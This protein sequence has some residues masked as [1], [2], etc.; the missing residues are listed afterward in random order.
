MFTLLFCTATSAALHLYLRRRVSK[1]AFV[2]GQRAGLKEARRIV[3]QKG[4]VT[5]YLS[6]KGHLSTGL[7]RA[8]LADDMA[9]EIGSAIN[10]L[11]R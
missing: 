3:K 4:D 1:A 2:D 5:L 9:L 8:Q 7:V 10:Q 11:G 6:P